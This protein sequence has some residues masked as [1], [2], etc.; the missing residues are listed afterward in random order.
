MRSKRTTER[1][2]SPTRSTPSLT[3]PS[4]GL[5]PSTEANL[6]F[7]MGA[8]E[9]KYAQYLMRKSGI[10][11]ERFR[12]AGLVDH[13]GGLISPLDH[14]LAFLLGAVPGFLL[15]I[16]IWYWF[17]SAAE[18]NTRAVMLVFAIV[19]GLAFGVVLGVVVDLLRSFRNV[20]GVIDL[21]V[22][23]ARSV[24]DESRNVGVSAVRRLSGD[25]IATG[26]SWIVFLPVLELTLRR[27]LKVRLVSVPIIAVL[28]QLLKVV[29]PLRIPSD[30]EAQI[31]ALPPLSLEAV[32]RSAEDEAADEQKWLRYL[33]ESRPK[34]LRVTRRLR[35]AI[36]V[37]LVGVALLIF[38]VMVGGAAL[39]SRFI[40]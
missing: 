9:E 2:S 19:I 33:E 5:A 10:D 12:H 24:R 29:V 40:G 13:V 15:S 37:P 6:P 21:G 7:R 18:P 23:A 17:F 22:V 1:P 39:V 14:L 26:V 8:A 16:G 34:V 36:V 35:N 31:A 4:A 30:A 27:R 3:T 25:D 20:F 38:G 28:R 32:E 11:F